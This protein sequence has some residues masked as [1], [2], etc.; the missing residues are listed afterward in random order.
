[1]YA[2][3]EQDGRQYQV[4]AGDTLTVDLREEALGAE[5]AFDRVLAV[6]DGPNSRIGQPTIAG[7]VVRGKIVGKRKENKLVVQKIRRRK[8]SR[9]KTGHRQLMTEGLIIGI[10]GY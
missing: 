3:I 4:A 5:I 7:A 1:M 8:N 6:A 10:E 2:I 9:R